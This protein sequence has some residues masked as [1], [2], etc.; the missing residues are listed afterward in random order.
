MPHASASRRLPWFVAGDLNGFFGLVVDN[1]S[2]LGFIAAA[3]VGIF[4]FPAEVVFQRMFPG[5]ALGVLVGNLV[6]TAMARR[7]AAREGRADVTAM[8]LGLDAPTSIG[9]A[10]LV[11]GPAYVGFRQQGLD[12]AA[13]AQA[14]W[15]LGMASLVVM[16][17]LKLALSFAG[18]WITRVLPRA[19][20]LGSIGGA[21][22]AL[23]G[24]LPLVETLR[25]PVV[26]LA[27]LGLLLYVLLG[28]GRLPWG[29]PGVFA[30]FVL[31]TV[32][33]YGLGLAGLG[34][35]GFALPQ[36]QPL[37]FVLPWPSL[38]FVDGLA[39]TVPYLPLLLPFGL[40]MVV[41]GINVAESARA[42]GDDYRTR[43]VLLAEAFSTLVAGLCGG[44]AQT[45]PYIGQPAYKHMGARHG[46]TLL[47]GLFIGLGGILGYVATLVQWLPV[48]ALAPIIV[49]VGL[50]ITVQAFHESPRRHAPAVALAFLPAIAYLLG[51]KLGNPAWIA[52]DAFAA[53]YAGI[54][55][56][57]L[58]DL[59]TIV[60]LGNGFIITAMLW[61]TALVAIVEQ[62]PRRAAAVLLLAAALTLF[63]IVHSVDPRGGIYLPWN[64]EGLRA[65]IAWQFAA[66][67]AV[68]AALL[69]LLSL[70]K[71]AKAG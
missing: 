28:R 56:H 34:L 51:I 39:D 52:P 43:D 16:G 31:G 41:G 35:P 12:E 60:T 53:L 49:Y 6:Y 65:T 69:G 64:L 8:P 68:L 45:T 36:A 55:A 30:A 23:L 42:A 47:T 33:Y 38:G 7:L 70:Q 66:A 58:P 50:D 26:G 14:T 24:F 25:N 9:M 40:L 62:R 48:A 71:P 54:D 1:L 44:V 63:G 21:A 59:A 19:A 67:Y 4:G 61:S 15:Q 11:L 2:I 3:L 20:L 57:G 37:S 13:A 17:V 18:D 46:Y 22:L 5:T 29:V 10:L 27:S 32:L